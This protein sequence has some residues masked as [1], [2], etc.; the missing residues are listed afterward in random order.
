M[1]KAWQM[2]W[3]GTVLIVLTAAGCRMAPPGGSLSL[4]VYRAAEEATAQAA[5]EAPAPDSPAERAALDRFNAFY[6]EY[7]TAAIAAGLDAVYAPDAFFADPFAQ[8]QGREA[9]RAYFLAMA[10]PVESCT[11]EIEPPTRA[12][13]EYFIPWIM[14][15]RV[16]SAPK[17]EIVAPGVS[18]VRFNADGLVI[19]QQDYWDGGILYDHL[20]V[21]NR[22]TRHVRWRLGRAH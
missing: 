13:G 5:R 3:M 10:E 2:R 18:H 22:L 17:K 12:N 4:A 8:V 15:L 21:V 7:S 9:I 1:K 16:R 6:A 14:R 20:P 11:F 19:F